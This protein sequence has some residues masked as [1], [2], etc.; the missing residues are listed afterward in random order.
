MNKSNKKPS[1]GSSGS[2]SKSGSFV[3]RSDVILLNDHPLSFR[4]FEGLDDNGGKVDLTEAISRGAVISELGTP[5]QMVAGG[6]NLTGFDLRVSKKVRLPSHFFGKCHVNDA[7]STWST[8]KLV[9]IP[10]VGSQVKIGWNVGTRLSHFSRLWWLARWD[11]VYVI[12]CEEPLGG[13]HLL[14]VRAIE[15][16]TDNKV[17]DIKWRPQ[18][19]PVLV[20]R[21]PWMHTSCLRA[22][23]TTDSG[24]AGQPASMS[25]VVECL[26]DNTSTSVSKPIKLSVW[27]CVTNVHFCD[28]VMTSAEIEAN[29]K[30][31][32]VNPTE[33][34]PPDPPP[35]EIRYVNLQA[36]EA[37]DPNAAADASEADPAGA[38]EA[39]PGDVVE[40][41]PVMAI[42][43]DAR[44]R[45]VKT[46]GNQLGSQA[47]K[48]HFVRNFSFSD[49]TVG[50]DVAFT[51]DP[52]D[53]AKKGGESLMR[54]FRRNVYVTHDQ[55]AGYT[56]AYHFKIVTVR[57][58]YFAG[59][60][61]IFNSI[62]KSGMQ[63]YTHV[64]GGAAT[65][66]KIRPPLHSSQQGGG[67]ARYRNSPFLYCRSERAVTA[68]FRLD[69][70]NRTDE[71]AD[72][73]A[74]IFVRPGN[75]TFQVPL[76]PKPI[77][78]TL[79]SSVLFRSLPEQVSADDLYTIVR[80]LRQVT[81]QSDE[82]D[83]D[84]FVVSTMES[85]EHGALLDSF[86]S[87]DL[88]QDSMWTCVGTFDAVPGTPLAI[89]LPLFKLVDTLG[90]S[91]SSVMAEKI[92]RFANFEPTDISDFGPAIGEYQ[93]IAHMPA[94]RTANIA[95]VCLPGDMNDE[96]LSRIFG[97]DSILSVAGSALSSIG[98]A[99]LNGAVNTIGNMLGAVGIHGPGA[100]S[101]PAPPPNSL[102]GKIPFT[103]FLELFRLIIGVKGATL[104]QMLTQFGTLL[105]EIVDLFDDAG[106]RVASAVPIRV[107]VR[108]SVNPSTEIYERVDT[109]SPEAPSLADL[110]LTPGQQVNVAEDLISG[111]RIDDALRVLS[112]LDI[113]EL[114]SAKILKEAPASRQAIN[115]LLAKLHSRLT[116]SHDRP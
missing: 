68:I 10:A 109:V 80:E 14:S 112:N 23:G 66:F 50:T 74:Q 4:N 60:I 101:T 21:V 30:M 37:A 103:R 107:M 87:E 99:V 102:G 5:T 53:I 71:K 11:V 59:R 13:N 54:P 7:L 44:T 72:F 38:I 34:T 115:N 96:V 55:S 84:S 42:L 12:A 19:L 111:G 62:D 6:N 69:Q 27:N 97:L 93:L 81:L 108:M 116:L 61:S 29:T 78:K 41:A 16:N 26:A 65:E 8:A 90:G 47:G 57:G 67:K 76:K 86:S 100:Q 22:G 110:Y 113:D 92:S 94:S 63:V 48:W 88:D 98:G 83:S 104:P 43:P 32:T 9:P 89:P 1:G 49:T 33:S 79:G 91:G 17:R 39:T 2:S 15:L 35:E 64:V 52:Q 73:V 105:I 77:P 46:K 51:F 70:F 18:Q 40:S 20:V 25:I 3:N 24:G 106:T 82:M 95:H 58:P 114:R 45:T 31:F 85:P 75:T 28:P 36:D 56:E